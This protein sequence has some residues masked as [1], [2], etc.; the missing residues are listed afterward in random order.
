MRP[1]EIC[2]VVTSTGMRYAKHACCMK[3]LDMLVAEAVAKRKKEKKEGNYR[4]WWVE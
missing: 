4:P 2:G 1:C 3:C